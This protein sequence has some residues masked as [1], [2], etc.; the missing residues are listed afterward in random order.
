MYI[1]GINPIILLFISSINWIIAT[2]T[3]MIVMT[4]ADTL[5]GILC[6][7]HKKN[8]NN[9]NTNGRTIKTNNICET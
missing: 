3:I 7:N 2:V 8:S 5:K 1:Y 6:N 9:N 4:D